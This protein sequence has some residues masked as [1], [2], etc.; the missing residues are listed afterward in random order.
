MA[1]IFHS[2]GLPP[3]EFYTIYLNHIEFTFGADSLE[4]SNCY[5]M[6]G[7]Y[8]MEQH[9]YNRAVACFV[10]TA[11]IRGPKGGDCFYNLAVI[12]E[13]RGKLD[14]AVKMYELAIKLYEEEQGDSSMEVA[15]IN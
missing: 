6:M 1:N 10:R 3:I 14:V 15:K 4:A 8:Y 5:F 12:Y 9:Q 7:T 13:M 11:D 2:L